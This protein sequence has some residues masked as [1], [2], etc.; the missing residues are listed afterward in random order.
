[1]PMSRKQFK[2][3]LGPSIVLATLVWIGYSA[4]QETKAY[5]QTVS[6][7]YAMADTL[8]GKTLK[9]AG[10]VV[11]GTIQHSAGEVEFTITESDKTLRVKY[12][13]RDPLPDTFRDYAEAIVDGEYDGNGLFTA[14]KL[15]AKCASKYERE[16]E[17]GVYLPETT[18]L[19]PSSAPII[20][21]GS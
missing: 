5:Y 8:E 14:T 15:Q 13:G 19:N 17:A 9:V 7:L 11:P 6:E 20:G 16:S 3:V 10:E 18:Q 12:I 2:F 21:N 4:L 1:M